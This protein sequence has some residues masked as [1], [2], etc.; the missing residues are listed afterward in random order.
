MNKSILDK[1]LDKLKEVI[2]SHEK[3]ALGF[4]GGVDS[5]LLSLVA[6]QVLGDNFMAIT[7]NGDMISSEELVVAKRIASKYNINHLIIDVDIDH[8]PMFKDNP[9][10]RCYYC[11]KSLFT[12]IKNKAL[13][14][15][16]EKI[17]DG[18][19]VDDLGD[20]RPGLKAIE[21]LKVISPLRE[22]GLTKEDIRNISKMYKLETWD[23]ASAACLASRIPY[24]TRID[25]ESLKLVAKSEDYIKSLGFRVVRV[26]K[27]DDIARIEIGKD[28]LNKALDSNVVDL[29]NAKLKSY[30]FKH[31][32]LDLN[33]YS[34]G[35][36]NSSV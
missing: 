12:L 21:E 15:G 33:G 34:M 32:S 4:S 36:L 10:D 28:E 7:I 25:K 31:V 11:K 14:A 13:E 18:T 19:N 2:L 30:G 23:H 35:S 5:S 16:I 3:F 9:S 6:S 20:Y 22:A 17:S 8:I 27:H 24:G 29:I 1:K 26:R